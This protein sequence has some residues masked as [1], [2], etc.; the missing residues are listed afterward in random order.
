LYRIGPWT[1]D[2]AVELMTGLFDALKI[3]PHLSHAEALRASML[4][5]ITN[6]SK[7]RWVQ[8]SFWAPFIVVGEPRKE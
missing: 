5:M 2:S 4:H 6:P 7:P 1:T 3:N 8:P